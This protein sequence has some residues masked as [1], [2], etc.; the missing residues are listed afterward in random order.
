MLNNYQLKI[1]AAGLMVVDH[2]GLLFFPDVALFRIIG[3]FSFPLFILLLVDGERHTRHLGRYCLRLLLFGM[4]SQPI[5][6]LLFPSASWNILFIL[7]LGLI[8]LR[9]V[10][11]FPHW[12]L[13]IWLVVAGIAQSLNLD[14]GAYGI[15]AIA[16][17]RSLQPSLIWWAGWIALHLSLFIL[18]PDFAP[19]QAPAMAAPFLLFAANHQPGRKARWFYWFYPLHWLT[20]W[21]IEWLWMG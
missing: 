18:E 14:Y 11:R 2:V 7:L 19:L 9:L 3:R 4:I 17:I 10:R 16:L 13:V 5:I 15:G 1:L 12:Q 8:C 21:A 6:E 20:L